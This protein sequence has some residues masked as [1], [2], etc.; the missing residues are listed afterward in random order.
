MA[1]GLNQKLTV[2]LYVSK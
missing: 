1:G 2:S